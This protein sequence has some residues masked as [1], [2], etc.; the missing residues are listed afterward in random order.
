MEVSQVRQVIVIERDTAD[1]CC[2]DYA[3]PDTLA[4]TPVLHTLTVDRS[5]SQK[6]WL[7]LVKLYAERLTSKFG[8]AAIDE[9]G[10]DKAKRFLLGSF[11]GDYAL[12]AN[13]QD[14]AFEPFLQSMAQAASAQEN[15]G[16]SVHLTGIPQLAFR[17]GKDSTEVQQAKEMLRLTVDVS[18]AAPAV[19][20]LS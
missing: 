20:S 16:G 7:G 6:S 17:F 4:T 14:E 8:Y 19:G 18:R 2:T 5:P 1:R 15:N 12:G 10:N 11:N 3:S 13:M 9:Q